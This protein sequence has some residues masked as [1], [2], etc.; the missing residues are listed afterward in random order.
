MKNKYNILIITI[1]SILTGACDN[2]LYTEPENGII[3]DDFWKTKEDVHSAMMGCYASL[4]GNTSGGGN[5]I[6]YQ[7]FMWGEMRGDWILPG[8][9][10]PSDY[11]NVYIGEIYPENRFCQWNSFYRTIDYCNTLLHFAP[12]VLDH[13]PSFTQE[14]LDEYKA[15]ALALRALMYFY[16]TRTFSDVPLVLEATRNDGQDFNLPKSSQ[17]DILK[18]IKTDLFNAEQSA[19]Y[20]YGNIESD[21]GRITKYTINA[22][23][24]DV[25]LWCNQYD[26]VLTAC[27]KIINSGVFG[28]VEGDEKWFENLYVKGNSVEGIFEL[29]FSITKQN[30]YYSLFRISQTYKAS[31]VA[32]EE[33]FPYDPDAPLDSFDLRGDGCS[34]KGSQNM[35]IWKQVGVNR[36]EARPSTESYAN[37]II[38]HYAEI[39]LNKAEAINQLGQSSEAIKLVKTIRKR[40]NASK[41][42][43]QAPTDRILLGEYILNE[44]S[45]EFA[46]E[47]KRWFD[48]LRNA[49]RNHYERLD[50]ILEVVS[51]NAPAERQVTILNKYRDTLSHYLPIYFAEIENNKNLV[52]NPFYEN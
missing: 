46:F 33:F 41:T 27:N 22:I 6:P 36:D 30:P 9:S 50:L 47:G 37:I 12:Q 19:V 42:T 8:R 23:Q 29:P 31:A 32:A 24:S 15:E 4:L 3:L 39:L 26:S 18:Q 20:T 25:Y 49:K 45:R 10:A 38:Y 35:T 21:K 11:D 13:D 7:V 17:T 44:R 2:W 51:R 40:A 14:M 43:N 48:V 5:D 1:F 34:Y 28:L 16:L 52:Q